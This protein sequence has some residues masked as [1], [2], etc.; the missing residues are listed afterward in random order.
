MIPDP[1]D[2]AGIRARVI[3]AWRASPARFREDA[4]AEEDHALGG[5]HDRLMV[6]LAQNAA[7]AAHAAG[8]PGRLLFRLDG[9]T[10]VA[11]NT[12]APLDHAGVESLSTLR[13]SAKRDD[14][15]SV[16]R[17]GVGFA[18]VLSVS[19]EPMITSRSGAVRWS[20]A[21][22][23]QDVAA[24]PELAGE[25]E[26]RRGH[27]PAL[28][29]PRA[30]D[31][32]PPPSG[33]DTAVVLPLRDE[34]AVRLVARLL[35][36]VD[37]VLLLAL[38]GLAEIVVETPDGRRVVS[39]V[40]RRWRTLRR[41]GELPR[42]LLSD[43]PTEERE[44][45]TWSVT[46]AVRR[47]GGPV[48]RVVHAPTPTDEPNGLPAALIGSFP[49]DPSRRHVAAGRLRDEVAARAAA[50]YVELVREVAADGTD[51]A[52]VLDL[53]PSPVPVGE[54]DAVVRRAVLDRLTTTPVLPAASG[55]GRL[56][57]RDAVV[58]EGIGPDAVAALADAMPELVHPAWTTRRRTLD[59]LGVRRL[60]LA[61]VVDALADLR[62]D[63][64]QWRALY[65]ALA[66][67]GPAIR[68]SLGALPVPLQDGRVVRGPR[69]LLLPAERLPERLD[70]LGLRVV[71]PA[72]A[73]PLLELL[74]AKPATSRAVLGDPACAAA[75]LAAWDAVE[76][77]EEERA[78]A[79]GAVILEL[80]ATAA[81]RPGELAWL[82]ELPLR[83]EHGELSEA[84]ELVL[85]DAPIE[86]VLAD[87][88]APDRA[89][90]ERW[91][92]E[93]LHAAGVLRTFALTRDADVPLD[94]SDHALDGEDGWIAEVL[95]VTGAGDLPLFV[96]EFVAVR[97]LDLVR[98]D[99]W[100][101]ALALLS[102]D[103]ELRDAVVQPTV[104]RRADGTTTGVP[105][106]TSWWLRKHALVAGRPMRDFRVAGSDAALGG[107]WHP[108]PADEPLGA[109]DPEILRAAGVRTSLADL[110]SEA[111]GPGE[112]LDR[113]A[114][115]DRDVTR[116]QL[117]TLYAALA[118]VPPARID[119]PDRV[120]VPDG[121]G[122]RVVPARMAAVLDEPQWL[123]LPM[124][125]AWVTAP[126]GAAARL[127]DVLDLP[128]ASER[129]VG[130]PA[131][132]VSAE[133]PREVRAVLPGAPGRWHEH[134]DLMV[135]G[136][137]V[138]WWV[139]PSGVVHAATTGGLARALAWAAGAWSRRHLVEAV[140]AAPD[141]LERLAAEADLED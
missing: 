104:V 48:P 96:D 108:L 86:A 66:A 25:L 124:S 15:R 33:Y 34:D 70:L 94:D 139:D 49:L 8:V 141:Q 137:S 119:P 128:L 109:V 92:P 95:R 19:D 98:D 14:R 10:L 55:A 71:D 90:L 1:F 41:D 102:S 26:R 105:S 46:W 57:P 88:A 11:A 59:A 22:T 97:D 64:D 89:V 7:D 5:Y 135:D 63:P 122:T 81:V 91:G 32:E 114:D 115:A 37:D 76:D 134:D 75:V 120:R 53:V 44:R 23:R 56:R 101:A 28:R 12:G 42:E 31:V 6:E 127:A 111:A 133:V 107:L 39:D 123:Q 118:E 112:L 78:G 30:A 16:G 117:R 54:L 130:T 21:R 106:Y 100:P 29:L 74:G 9:T 17:F 52:P 61:D 43:R 99:A 24:I 131:G 50:A 121:T 13:A 125:T 116:A 36:E 60:P 47:D 82:G 65:E 126:L 80:V 136:A 72:A 110:L 132:G 4:N 62:L 113:L 18:A 2:T 83:D 138:E 35:G 68:E 87:L 93:T 27:V 77:G 140:L 38:P 67:S 79:L 58:V 84:R 40:V 129:D 85:P 45:A 51:P 69:G 20:R 73:H 3:T 103:R